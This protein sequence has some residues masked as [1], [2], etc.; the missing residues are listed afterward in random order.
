L[1]LHGEQPRPALAKRQCFV[2]TRLH[3]PDHEEPQRR[4]QDDRRQIEQPAWPTATADVLYFDINVLL[5]HGLVHVGVV[6]RHNRPE[7]GLVVLEL[8]SN[9]HPVDGYFPDFALLHF[10]LELR[11]GDWLFLLAAAARPDY[12]PQQKGRE[13]DHQPKNYSFHGRIHWDSSK[14]AGGSARS[15]RA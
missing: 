5:L 9:F 2:A 1:L 15:P 7:H 4:Q 10:C 12:L 3:L 14:A 11:E 13:H 8:P 6:R